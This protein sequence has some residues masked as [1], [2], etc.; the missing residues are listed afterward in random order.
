MSEYSI[1]T[2]DICELAHE[3]TVEQC[4]KQGITVDI[5]TDEQGESYTA[6]AQEVFNHYYEMIE[7]HLIG[8]D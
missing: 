4:Q 3:L 8:N 2:A 5:F 1:T 7:Q 6:E